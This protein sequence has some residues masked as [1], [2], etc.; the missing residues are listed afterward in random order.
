[1]RGSAAAVIA[2]EHHSQHRYI[3]R[4]AF[5]NGLR[6]LHIK[7]SYLKPQSLFKSSAFLEGMEIIFVSNSHP[8]VK[9]LFRESVDSAIWRPQVVCRGWW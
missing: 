4:V 6:F 2:D 8:Y 9:G 3:F 1:M 7:K 5:W